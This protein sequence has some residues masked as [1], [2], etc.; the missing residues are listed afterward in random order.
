M[1]K[2]FWQK[3]ELIITA[4][5][6]VLAYIL[7]YFSGRVSILYQGLLVNLCAGT[8]GS[9]ITI[10]GIEFLRKRQAK[11]FLTEARGVTKIHM[12]RLMNMLVSHI[13]SP[14]GISVMQYELDRENLGSN[15]VIKHIANDLKQ[16][17]IQEILR[18]M[19]VENWKNLALNLPVIRAEL[20]DTF[21][22]YKDV[23]PVVV[24]GKLLNVKM[25]FDNFYKLFGGFHDLFVNEE[26]GW[27]RNE[28][29]IEKNREVREL[30]MKNFANELKEYF[31]KISVLFNLLDKIKK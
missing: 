14:L 6:L 9:V 1:L 26:S 16:K 30:L 11:T 10:W 8:V 19:S 7:W 24:I 28:S 27:P 18:K 2:F 25:A 15:A 23:L 20:S 21:L 4:L 5:L 29:G 13:A 17:N 22:L 3:I 12:T 31:I